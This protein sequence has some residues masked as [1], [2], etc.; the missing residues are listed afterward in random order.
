MDKPLA[1]GLI[2]EEYENAIKENPP[3]VSHHEGC[4]VI[5]EEFEELWDE[6]KKKKGKRDKEKLT[7]EAKQVGAM[8]MRFMIDLL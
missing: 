8:A 7:K 4:S 1:V 6:V 5:R 3:F 2:L